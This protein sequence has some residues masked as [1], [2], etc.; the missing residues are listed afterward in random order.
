VV[1]NGETKKKKVFKS[2]GEKVE[3]VHLKS[4]PFK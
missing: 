3:L 1:G 2:N 4:R